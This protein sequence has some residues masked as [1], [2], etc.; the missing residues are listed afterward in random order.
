MRSIFVL[1]EQFVNAH[2]GCACDLSPHRR[3]P[4]FRIQ[5]EEYPAS[6]SVQRRVRQPGFEVSG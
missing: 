1:R 4:T 5:A 2:G 6:E 3:S